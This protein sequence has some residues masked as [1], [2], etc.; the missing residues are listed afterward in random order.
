[1]VHE[2][3]STHTKT[4][5]S[6]S[7]SFHYSFKQVKTPKRGFLAPEF[8]QTLI[9]IRHT[10]KKKHIPLA[11]IDKWIT[12]NNYTE[13]ECLLL[14]RE[15]SSALPWKRLRFCAQIGNTAAGARALATQETIKMKKYFPH[16]T[17]A[18]SHRNLNHHHFNCLLLLLS[19]HDVFALLS[20]LMPSQKAKDATFVSIQFKL[21]ADGD[22]VSA[23]PTSR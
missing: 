17:R 6:W 2:Y 23:R 7:F 22:A 4:K 12:S 13:S 18:P 16:F 11:A 9:H 19:N 14:L 10:L 20:Y 5:E 21:S 3:F 8:I 15:L 1:M